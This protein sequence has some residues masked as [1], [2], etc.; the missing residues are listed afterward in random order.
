MNG[1]I[2]GILVE[3]KGKVGKLAEKQLSL[4]KTGRKQ[5]VEKKNRQNHLEE[6]QENPLKSNTWPRLNE[7]KVI[8]R[9]RAIVGKV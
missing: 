3:M 4:A 5:W 2:E 6:S 1:R 9:I 7:N 8:S